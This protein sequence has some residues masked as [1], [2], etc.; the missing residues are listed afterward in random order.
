MVIINSYSIAV[1][2]CVVTMLCWGSWANTLKLAKK[3]WAYPLYYWDYS[4]GLVLLAL[5]FGL[6]LGSTGEQGQGFIENFKT[7]SLSN[8]GNAFIG[9][10]IFNLSNLLIVA[11]TAIAGMS[12]AFPIAVGLALVIGVLDNYIRKS[13]GNP[14]ILFVGVALIV[15]AIVINSIAY[16]KHSK[17]QQ[18]GSSSKGIIISILS[19]VI[20]GFF[21]GFVAKTLPDN[22]AVVEKGALTPYNAVFIFTIGVFLSNFI[23]NSWFMY[24][25]ISGEK[26]T[27]AQYFS[28][29]NFKLHLIGILGGIIWNIGMSFSI[30]ASDAAGPAISYGLGQGATMIAAAWGVFVWKEF[31]GSSKATNWLITAMFIT[32][33]VG[34]AMIIIARGV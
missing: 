26:V 13:E 15:L 24:K 7:A 27:Y 8:M 28:D 3:D 20:M 33:I 30:L 19:G 34:L 9:G 11:A 18:Q 23:F 29:G 1:L 25:P 16:R 17:N 31:K 14:V 10:V 21:F 12:V 2:L 4:I 32:F 6:T 5:I 22:F